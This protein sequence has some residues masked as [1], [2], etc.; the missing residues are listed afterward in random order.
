ME[1]SA[2]YERPG[3]W[4]ISLTYWGFKINMSLFQAWVNLD[5]SSTWCLM[6]ELGGEFHFFAWDGFHSK[7]KAGSE[8]RRRGVESLFPCIGLER[9]IPLK[10]T[11]SRILSQH[12]L[13]AFLFWNSKPFYIETEWIKWEVSSF[14]F[15]V[16]SSWGSV[17]FVFIKSISLTHAFDPFVTWL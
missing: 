7:G 5:L 1:S 11:Y 12:F 16:Y 13:E 3:R 4:K 2:L 10:L 6:E 9:F 14:L 15:I 8:D 17:P